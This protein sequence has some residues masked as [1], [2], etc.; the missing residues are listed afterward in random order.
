MIWLNFESFLIMLIIEFSN[1]EIDFVVENCFWILVVM[2][3]ILI[4][5][6]LGLRLL[7]R[8]FGLEMIGWLWV[9]MFE[10]VVRF[11]WL[12]FRVL[13]GFGGILVC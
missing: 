2:L 5:D 8:V 4:E 11:M 12:F 6:V 9:C 10:I 1:W 13:M 3:M 7:Y